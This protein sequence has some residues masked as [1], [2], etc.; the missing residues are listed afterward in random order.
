MKEQINSLDSFMFGCE[1]AK[2]KYQGGPWPLAR[3]MDAEYGFY[4]YKMVERIGLT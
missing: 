1:W 3:N 2:V 4:A